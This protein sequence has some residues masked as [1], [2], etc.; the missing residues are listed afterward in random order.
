MRDPFSENS[1]KSSASRWET[2]QQSDEAGKSVN[3]KTSERNW[4]PQRREKLKGI[5]KQ[6]KRAELKEMKL[7]N[8]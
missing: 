3:M 4:G 7:Q 6:W 1:D 2:D 5:H 8:N